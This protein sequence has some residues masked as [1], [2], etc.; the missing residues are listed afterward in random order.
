[1]VMRRNEQLAKSIDVKHNKNQ[2]VD[3]LQRQSLERK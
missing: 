3:V 1:M 2:S